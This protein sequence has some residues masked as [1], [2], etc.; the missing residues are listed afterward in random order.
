MPIVIIDTMSFCVYRK[1]IM[2]YNIRVRKQ[3]LINVIII[4]IER[5]DSE[6]CRV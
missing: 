5:Y 2:L 4:V 6:C 1:C 3:G